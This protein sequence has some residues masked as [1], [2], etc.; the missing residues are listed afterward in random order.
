MEH[1]SGGKVIVPP[2]QNLDNNVCM[3]IANTY[4][5]AQD[6]MKKREQERL[7]IRG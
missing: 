7:N 2:M 3:C 1:G 5:Y 6:N 4:V